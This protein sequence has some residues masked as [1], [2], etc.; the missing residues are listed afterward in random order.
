MGTQLFDAADF[1]LVIGVFAISIFSAPLNLSYEMLEKTAC[2]DRASANRPLS[3]EHIYI[4]YPTLKSLTRLLRSL[5]IGK[6]SGE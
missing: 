5:M 2:L 6:R 3:G 4:Q 1:G